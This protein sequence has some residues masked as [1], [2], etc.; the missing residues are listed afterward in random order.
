MPV[1]ENGWNRD[2]ERESEDR[3]SESNREKY[4]EREIS[5]PLSK[6]VWFYFVLFTLSKQRLTNVSKMIKG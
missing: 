3:E 5:L 1:L 2:I 4:R 6:Q